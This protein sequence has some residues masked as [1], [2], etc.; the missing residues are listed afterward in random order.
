MSKPMTFN[1]PAT[2][3]RLDYYLS[4]KVSNVT[5]NTG[6]ITLLPWAGGSLAL[7]IFLQKCWLGGGSSPPA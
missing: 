1:T 6:N 7:T 5:F 4:G 2:G 3:V